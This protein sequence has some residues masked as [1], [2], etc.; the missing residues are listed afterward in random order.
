MM[1]VVDQFLET[2]EENPRL[3][4]H[5]SETN[6]EPGLSSNINLSS[7]LP[8]TVWYIFAKSLGIKLSP[9]D[10]PIFGTFLHILTLA[11]AFL[12]A[13]P[14][15]WYTV[16]DIHSEY[17]RTTVLIGSVEIVIGFTWACMGVYAH[18]L[19]GRLFGN[20]NFVECVRVH[21]KTFLKVSTSWLTVLL[22]L[23][24][25]GVNC[26]QA[27]DT[28]SGSVCQTVQ[29][30]VAVCKVFYIGRV[31]YAVVMLVWNFIVAYIIFSVCRTHTIGIRR[32]MHELTQ[33]A[34]AYEDYC[35]EQCNSN[36][37]R[38]DTTSTPDA[39]S[40][41]LEE[42]WFLW[43]DA[44]MDPLGD[45]VTSQ[46]TFLTSVQGLPFRRRSS[47]LYRP[48][49]NSSIVPSPGSR[50]Q[51]GVPHSLAGDGSRRRSSD[52]LHH[53][54]HSQLQASYIMPQQESVNHVPGGQVTQRGESMDKDFTGSIE[55]APHEDNTNGSINSDPFHDAEDEKGTKEDLTTSGT[56]EVM[57]APPI[58]SN[59]D[60][61]FSYWKFMR[62]L[63]VT[64]RYLQR[65]LASW[66]A[67]VVIWD[68]YFIIYWTSHQASLIDILQFIVPLLL[69]LLLCSAYAE[70]NAEG[71]RLLKTI[72]PLENRLALI[73]YFNQA[74]LSVKVF[75]FS[76]SYNAMMTVILGFSVAFAS[77]MIL[78]EI[79]RN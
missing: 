57:A 18:K 74:P 11:T 40:R 71:Q 62:R 23:L 7:R 53:M 34:K 38:R 16:Y 6:L 41:G 24:V 33:D 54:M 52:L 69:L 47:A 15:A 64:S 5:D 48:T 75:S 35:M 4:R 19:A 65:W 61:L 29:V 37:G 30:H 3:P 68:S 28:F 77:R 22:G 12:F 9:Q 13:V 44:M 31:S 14:G 50:R 21:S 70:V 25:V 8:P 60:L 42:S 27:A 56:H 1:P 51:S 72:C 46:E 26:Y 17:S 63:C 76:V 10:R 49:S 67:F 79:A 43:D 55:H 58:L 66:I 45:D 36:S 20:K 78:D 59:D 2:Q 32:F 39:I 73:F